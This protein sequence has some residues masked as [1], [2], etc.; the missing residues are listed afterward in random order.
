MTALPD[1]RRAQSLVA[2]LHKQTVQEYRDN[3]GTTG[4]CAIADGLTLAV[5]G[6]DAAVRAAENAAKNQR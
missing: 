2:G 1:L 6:I 5:E 4:L 3:P